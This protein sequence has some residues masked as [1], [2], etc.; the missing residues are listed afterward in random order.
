ML[1]ANSN[2]ITMR[3]FLNAVITDTIDYEVISFAQS[4]LDKLNERNA[5]RAATPS[6][7]AIANAP[8]KD[9]ILE[10]LRRHNATAADIAALVSVTTQK[11]SALC[12]QMVKEGVLVAE[13]VKIPKKGKVKMYSI[14]E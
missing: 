5:K 14:V 9:A 4:Q 13:E 7:T 10:V 1:T 2:K 3:D 12:V 8:I 11:A 6:K